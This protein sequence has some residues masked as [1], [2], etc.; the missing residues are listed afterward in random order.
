MARENASSGSGNGRMNK[1][2][3]EEDRGPFGIY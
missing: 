2:E 1:R 3:K